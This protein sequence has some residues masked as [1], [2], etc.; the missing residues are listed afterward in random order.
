MTSSFDRV[1]DRLTN[2]KPQSDG[3]VRAVCPTAVHNGNAGANLSVR[4]GHKGVLLTCWSH[5]CDYRDIAEALG[6]TV[7]DLFDEPATQ[8]MY[9]DGRIVHRHNVTKGFHQSGNRTGHALYNLDELKNAVHQGK[10]VYIVEGE[11]DVENARTIAGVVATCNPGGAGKAANADWEPLRGADIIVVQDKDAPG[12]NHAAQIIA[13]LIGLARTVALRQAKVGKDL[14][15]HLSAY[16][17]VDNLEQP[18]EI[19]PPQQPDLFDGP[20]IPLT[21]T[22]LMPAFPVGAFPPPIGDMITATAEF[23]QTDP[24]MPGTSALGA[25]SAC[26]GGHVEIQIRPGWCEPLCLYLVTVAAPGE[27]K[28]AVQT[29]IAR[30]IFDQEQQ[31][32]LAVETERLEAEARR[33]IA[34]KRAARLSTEAARDIKDA[35]TAK[36]ADAE[37]LGAAAQAAAIEVPAIP[38][39]VADDITPE[40]AATL[41]AEQG[42]RLAIISAEGGVFDI[43]AGR[44]S[45][46]IPNLDL[47]LKGH[48]GDPMKVDRK[49]RP[50]EYVRRPALTLSLMVQPAT[51]SAVARTPM[52]RGRGLLARI[53]YAMPTSNV[54][55]RNTAPASVDQTV[56]DTYA[57]TIQTLAAGLHGW[58]GDPAILML[59]PD[60][61][62]AVRDLEATIEPTLAGDGELA[63]L[64]DWGAK[65]VGA[66]AR[67]TGMLHLA[68]HGPNGVRIP[69]A[70]DTVH[71]ATRLGAYFKA[72]AIAAFIEMG[73][74]AV[75]ADAMYLLERITRLGVDE[76]SERDIHKAARKFRAKVDMLPALQRLVDHE[77]IAKV[78]N[79]AQTGGRP[80]IHYRINTTGQ[81]AQKGQNPEEAPPSVTFGP[82]APTP[83]PDED[84]S[85]DN[86]GYLPQTPGA[87]VGQWIGSGTPV[88]HEHAE[89]D[90]EDST[91]DD[92]DAA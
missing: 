9:A 15:D 29:T 61:E 59:T 72:A 13:L 58:S 87:E 50:P 4:Q 10:T 48:S 47:W 1:V 92:D 64:A 45:R 35:E 7:S 44:Y 54:G 3:S 62:H 24:A 22:P 84:D 60:A 20:P 26:T 82:F 2:V 68:T 37:A 42:G 53:L 11:K 66:V 86:R 27:R 65:Y 30:P 19:Q 38:R 17:T 5:Q 71:A 74:D 57:S 16:G 67:I 76:I 40:A 89:S 32:G 81:K 21:D 79:T 12:R 56:S 14:T 70:A 75:T 85:D 69:V 23:T 18:A 77:Y 83:C 34:A 63:P 46:N 41:L 91:G 31:L 51:L 6:L 28:S 73:T 80:T 33:E 8:Y 25:L 88:T 52:F 49:G 39:L 90:N 78:P 55:H 36:N 43:I